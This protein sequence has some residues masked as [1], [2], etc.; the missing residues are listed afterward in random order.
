MAA[1]SAAWEKAAGKSSEMARLRAVDRFAAM[2]EADSGAAYAFG[3]QLVEAGGHARDPSAIQD[4]M[5][6]LR[7][8]PQP[9]DAAFRTL[10]RSAAETA[11]ALPDPGQSAPH[12]L[13]AENLFL[14]GDT[15]RARR[16]GALAVDRAAPEA[17]EATARYV[18][19]MQKAVR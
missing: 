7:Q 2:R 16:E 4:L 6:V 11:F 13:L 17:R 18:A 14:L 15:E 10:V 5:L 12:L 19:Q 9:G 3:R 8:H 1:G